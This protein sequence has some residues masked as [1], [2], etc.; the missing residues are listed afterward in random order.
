MIDTTT[1]ERLVVERGAESGPYIDLPWSQV[2][3]VRE[4]LDQAG[5]AYWVDPW[6]I[7]IEGHPETTTIYFSRYVDAARIQAALD[8]TA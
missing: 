1:G 5:I 2:D 8:K 6:V 3:N 4:R 7:S